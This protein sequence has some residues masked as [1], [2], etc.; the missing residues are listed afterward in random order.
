MLLLFY[1]R[2][3]TDHRAKQEKNESSLWITRCDDSLDDAPLVNTLLPIDQAINQYNQSTQ[4]IK[5][6][7]MQMMTMMMIMMMIE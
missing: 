1:Y 2:Y 4:S 3:Y 6:S 5:K 7:I